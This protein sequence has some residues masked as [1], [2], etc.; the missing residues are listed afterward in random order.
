MGMR[1]TIVGDES[2]QEWEWDGKYREPEPGES[3]LSSMGNIAIYSQHPEGVAGI[4]ARAIVHK[5]PKTII[6]G[7]IEWEI[8]EAQA[9]KAGEWG[10]DIDGFP[11]VTS[12]VPRGVHCILKPV[13]IVPGASD[14]RLISRED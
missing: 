4:N 1:F 13:R 12:F 6:A 9:I 2:G 14:A 5:V 7:G 11:F 10:L 8:G 3:F